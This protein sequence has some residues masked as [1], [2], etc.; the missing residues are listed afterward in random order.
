[1]YRHKWFVAGLL[2]ALTG[3]LNGDEYDATSLEALRSGM[4]DPAIVESHDGS[5]Y[6]VFA[7]GHGVKV[8]HSADLLSWKQIGR[9]FDRHVPEWAEKA[10]PGC[11]GI[12]AP[13]IRYFNGQ[14]YL[15]YSVSTF[16]S[17]R[18]VIGL[19]ISKSVNP[20]SP[21]YGWEDQGVV[22]ESFAEKNDFNAIDPA[23]FSD[24]NGKAYLYWGSYWTG[25]KGI[26]IDPQTGKPFDGK[27]E[28]VA[29]AQRT[30][31]GIPTNIEAPFMV[32][33][34]ESYY[35]MASWDFCCAGEDS[36]YKVVVGRSQSPLGP[37]V[38]M[39]QRTMDK[40]GGEVILA[41]DARWR[42]PGHNSFLQTDKGDY[43]VH[44]VY[45]G[46]EVKKGRILQVRPV[47]W[48]RDGWL[49]VKSPLKDP[50]AEDRNKERLSPLVGAWTHVVDGKDT[51][52]I[53]LEASG[54]ISGTAGK[55]FWNRQGKKLR[56]RWLDPQAPN[57]VWIDE[58][59]LSADGKT[60]YGK[61]Q[62]GTVIEG[63]KR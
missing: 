17:Q 31:T 14:Y 6:Y 36:T 55:S 5:G 23:V 35:L 46:E 24:S 44:H 13:D 41:S 1:M 10:V 47:T 52:N 9:V 19:A 38:D 63:S 61:N 40:G 18:S 27:F 62:N 22:V 51:Y 59:T 53:F 42:G 45:D 50:L 16:G 57:G 34:R 20:E 7:T 33:H 15:Y 32:K 4:P 29:L 11:D 28:Y 60:Y 30:A 43:L 58:V 3:S 2:L 56:M 54:E 8:F 48:T 21:D 26:E 37:F 39:Q 12:W 25:I 49:E